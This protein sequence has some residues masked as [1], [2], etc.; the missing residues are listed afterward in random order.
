M[1]PLLFAN[2]DEEIA[3]SWGLIGRPESFELFVEVPDGKWHKLR[4][5]ALRKLGEHLG[6]AWRWL[7]ILQVDE[8]TAV[9]VRP[10]ERGWTV[11]VTLGAL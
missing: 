10:G 3:D 5:Q 6:L 7:K 9:W 11:S 2:V 8:G 4:C 1:G